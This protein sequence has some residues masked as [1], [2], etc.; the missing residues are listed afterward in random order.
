[1]NRKVGEDN[2]WRRS[3]VLSYYGSG[4]CFFPCFL[5]SFLFRLV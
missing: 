2:V 1:M 5:L 3:D 4:R